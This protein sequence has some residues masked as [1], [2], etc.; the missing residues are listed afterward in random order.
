VSYPQVGDH[1]DFRENRLQQ[2]TRDG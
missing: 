1:V 2:R